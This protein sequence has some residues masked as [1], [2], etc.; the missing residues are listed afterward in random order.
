MERSRPPLSA[1]RTFYVGD[2]VWK[3]TPALKPNTARKLP[4]TGTLFK[5]GVAQ[6]TTFSDLKNAI[7]SAPVLVHVDTN[8]PFIVATDASDY[9]IGGVLSQLDEDGHE[10]VG[11]YVSRSLHKAEINYSVT[12]KEALALYW[13]VRQWRNYLLGRRFTL[14]TSA[15]TCLQPAPQARRVRGGTAFTGHL[16]VLHAAHLRGR[17]TNC[18]GPRA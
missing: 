18:C 4:N 13:A 10:R 8:K 3:L 12:D 14:Y 5:W 7:A 9:A 16:G 1:M 6:Q 2:R 15:L 17:T 11:A